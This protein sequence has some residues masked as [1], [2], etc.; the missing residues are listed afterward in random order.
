MLIQPLTFW[1]KV[2]AFLRKPTKLS[3]IAERVD[4]WNRTKKAE[5]ES[6]RVKEWLLMVIDQANR[7]ATPDQVKAML[8]CAIRGLSVKQ[9]VNFNKSDIP[10]EIQ[11]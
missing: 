8:S 5:A 9:I 2:S 10:Q 3:L 6:F 7:G 11:K 4:Q 1:Q